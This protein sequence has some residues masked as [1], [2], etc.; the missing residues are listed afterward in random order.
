MQVEFQTTKEDYNKFLSFYFFKRN[1][2]TRLLFLILISLWIGCS[3]NVHPFNLST[4][5]L[6]A[7]IG[8]TLLFILF[9]LAPYIIAKINFKKALQKKFLTETKTILTLDEG[10]TITSEN[11]NTFWK[12]E[13]LNKAEILN[14]YLFVSLFTRKI[15]I[16]PLSFFASNN[17]AINFLGVIKN[18]IQKVRGKS[19]HRK[20]RN[21]YYWGLVGF[22]PNFGVIAGIVLIIKGFQYNKMMLMLIGIGD[23]LFT[24]FFWTFLFPSFNSGGFKDISQM[25]LTSLVKNVEFYKL[26][27]GQYPDSLQQLLTDDKSAPIY[28]DIQA[29]MLKRKLPLYNY[30][31][32]GDKY[33]L[34][35]SGLDGVPNTKDDFYPKINIDS[36]KIGLIRQN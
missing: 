4:F 5:I 23:I 25:N 13:T 6:Q 28:D 29:G 14:E 8:A 16:I 27:H 24:F 18:G 11:E 3:G 30:K 36:S 32:L 33:V 17:E 1:V 31:R 9:A 35:S 21:L 15:Y 19:K 12:W 22:I 20:I 10:I 7:F 26:Q 34:F 2:A